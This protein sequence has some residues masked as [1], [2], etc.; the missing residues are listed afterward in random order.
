MAFFEPPRAS[1]ILFSKP[2]CAFDIFSVC[3]TLKLFL[4]LCYRN[5]GAGVERQSAARKAKS[6]CLAASIPGWTISTRLASIT[7]PDRFVSP[8]SV[9][10]VASSS[11]KSRS[12]SSKSIERWI[13]FKISNH[14][15]HTIHREGVDLVTEDVAR[16]LSDESIG[17]GSEFP[18]V[19][20]TFSIVLINKRW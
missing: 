4:L 8:A 15:Y 14:K 1:F 9:F 19:Y 7:Q 3:L 5:S 17:A 2:S 10:D 13:L 11:D 6:D 12:T 20:S 18:R 16:G